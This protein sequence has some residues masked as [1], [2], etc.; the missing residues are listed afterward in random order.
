[1]RQQ[2]IVIS[3]YEDNTYFFT[4]DHCQEHGLGDN[5]VPC[6]HTLPG[7]V[8]PRNSVPDG[9]VKNV[10][11]GVICKLNNDKLIEHKIINKTYSWENA[12]IKFL[13]NF[14]MDAFGEGNYK[15]I[16]K[17]NI[18]ANFGGRIHYIRFNIDY[19]EFSSTRKDDLQI[20]NGKVI[21]YT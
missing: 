1:M 19:T 7:M 12:Y 13:D 9:I 16:D 20:V 21:N 14:K 2:I 10:N 15:I 4:K 18:I 5:F 17:Q 8:Q 6:T 3:N 11:E